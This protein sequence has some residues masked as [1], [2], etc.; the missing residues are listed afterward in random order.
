[1]TEFIAPLSE[2]EAEVAARYDRP[3][4]GLL[5]GLPISVKECVDIGG[6]DTTV[7][8]SRRLNQPKTDDAVLVQVQSYYFTVYF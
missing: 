6:Q 3:S 1:V 8:T 2:L 7:G 5:Q 4:A